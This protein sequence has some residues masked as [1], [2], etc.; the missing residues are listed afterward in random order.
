MIL[1]GGIGAGKSTV[2]ALFGRLGAV[3]IDADSAG[4]AVLAPGGEAHDAVAARW[5]EAV[6]T[7]GVIDRAALA[8]IVFADRALLTELEGLTHP[9]IRARIGD[10]VAAADQGILVG[11]GVVMVEVPL[12]AS[13]LGPGW[14]RVVVDVPAEERRRRLLARGMDGAGIERRMAAQPADDEW[15]AGADLVV[16][17][18]GPEEALAAEVARVWGMLVPGGG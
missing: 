2:G 6:T 1:S 17:N 11:A 10:L 7:A 12:A 9:A 5:P 8:R 13:F 18:S 14:V 3:V 16:D 4:H 15:R